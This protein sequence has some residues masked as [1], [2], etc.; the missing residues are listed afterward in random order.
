MITCGSGA[1]R[2]GRR[3]PVATGR[4]AAVGADLVFAAPTVAVAGG[5]ARRKEQEHGGQEAH[6]GQGAGD[7]RQGAGVTGHW[8]GGRALMDEHVE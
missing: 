2:A 8:A 4:L 1:I 7:R 5:K 6:D 3:C